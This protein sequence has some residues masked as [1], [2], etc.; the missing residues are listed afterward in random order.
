MPEVRQVI[1]KEAI[2]SVRQQPAALLYEVAYPTNYLFTLE[3]L[4]I[5]RR[6]CSLDLEFNCMDGVQCVWAGTNPDIDPFALN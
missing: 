5:L 3:G 6:R 1:V 2:C 4:R